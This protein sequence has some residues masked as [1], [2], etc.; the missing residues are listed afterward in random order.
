MKI[1]DLPAEPGVYIFM[2][3]AGSILYIGKA[4]SIIKRVR[5]HFSRDLDSRHIAMM[6]QVK[7]VDFIT[8]SN[9]KEALVLEDQLIKELQPRYNIMMRDDKTYPFIEIT[10][11]DKYPVLRITRKKNKGLGTLYFGPFPNVGDI[12][13]AKKAIDAI[14]PLR[15]CGKFRKR[16]RPCLNYQI[17]RCLSPCTGRADEAVY[18]EIVGEAVMFLSGKQSELLDR[19]KSRMD[20]FKDEKE[21]ERAAAVRD[22]IL[23]LENFFPVVNF[24]KI[25]RRKLAL[26]KKVDPMYMLKNLL[27]MKFKPETIEGYDISHTASGEAAG[28]RVL[29][30]DGEP[31][32]SGYRRYRIKGE[33]TF[34]DIRMLG[35]VIYRR[36][37]RA[38]DASEKLPDIMLIDGGRSQ[39]K[40]ASQLVEKFGYGEK[41]RVLSLAKEKGN[42]YSRGKILPVDNDSQLYMLLKSV[43]DEAHR[44]ARS[45]HIKRRRRKDFPN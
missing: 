42:V 32:T 45:Y 29:F 28:S 1:K 40:V 5:S 17:G 14:F 25:G 34:D 18:R 11:G 20:S 43:T 6:S 9:E 23:K 31:D 41:V 21:Y 15:K 12:R 35:E 39:E 33:P 27:D 30:R 22:Q 19:L 8:T 2:D 38:R 36:L 13:A 10:A 44:F 16:K 4:K 3:S 37:C 24:R 26:L 7:T